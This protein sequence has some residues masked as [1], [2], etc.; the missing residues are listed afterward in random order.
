MSSVVTCSNKEEVC[1]KPPDVTQEPVAT[2]KTTISSTET[3]AT[4]AEKN[5]KSSGCGYANLNEI[6]ERIVGNKEDVATFAEFPW[7][8]TVLEENPK[9]EQSYRCGGALIHPRVVITAAHCITGRNKK[10]KIRAGEFNTQITNEPLPH[11]DIE[12]E[13]IISHPQFYA[14]THYNN[15]AVLILKAS[16]EITGNVNIIC[17]PQ[18]NYT[19]I[20]TRCYVSGWGKDASGK[21]GKYQTIPKKIDVPVI[22]R[23]TC[24][25]RLR[26]TGLGRHFRLHKSLMCAGGEQGRDACKGDGGS[27]LMCPIPDQE[28]RFYQAGIVVYGIGC[29]TANIPGVYTNIASFRDWIDEQMHDHNLNINSYQ[30]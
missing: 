19:T 4:S 13:S 18:Q 11:Q 12:V 26:T 16:V 14:A 15:I 23:D 20:D 21:Q 29:G 28:G 8:V 5:T 6:E 25:T 9:K 1:C 17:L 2:I 24:Q 7:M 27:P 3:T 10:F 22:D 30:Y